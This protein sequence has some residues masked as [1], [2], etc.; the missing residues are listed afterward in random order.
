MGYTPVDCAIK[1]NKAGHG[2]IL[3]SLW[4]LLIGKN[5]YEKKHCL[6][7]HG[8]PN[9]GKSSFIRRVF[10]IFSTHKVDWR[11]L[12]LPLRDSNR[13]D[14]MTQVVV[15]E[16]F[17][18]EMAFGQNTLHVTKSLFDGSGGSLRQDLYEKFKECYG[19]AVFVVA[20][21]ELPDQN[22]R[23]RD[24]FKKKVWDP[25]KTRIDFTHFP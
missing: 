16:E 24:L 22:M 4:R 1:V 15:N 3:R 18:W 7:L 13:D 2:K 10:E 19:G 25:M 21:N 14:L 8:E 17:D 9:A 12:Y 20:S 5:E 11:G 6:W 23:E